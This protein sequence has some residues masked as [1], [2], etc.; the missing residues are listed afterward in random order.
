MK[1]S[2]EP[3]ITQLTSVVAGSE[4]SSLCFCKALSSFRLD[5]LLYESGNYYDPDTSLILTMSFKY[6]LGKNTHKNL[7]RI[8][9]KM[10]YTLF[11]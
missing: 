11:I 7:R 10:T 9:S 4:T 5:C 8:D 2:N 1:L 6:T 3:K